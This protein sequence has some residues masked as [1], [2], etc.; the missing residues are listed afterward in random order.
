MLT[1]SQLGFHAKPIGVLNT[2]GYFDGLLSFCDR[3]VADGFVRAAH[4]AMI[5]T[6]VDA[7]ELL[8][9]MSG[10]RVEG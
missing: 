3:A 8:G 4:R 5:H 10:A 7:G 2:A 9:R 6:G 1:W